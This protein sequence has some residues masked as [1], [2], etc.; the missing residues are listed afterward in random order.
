MRLQSDPTV[1][2]ALT[3]GAAPL[4]R[5]LTRDDLAFDSPFNT[6][7]TGGLPPAPIANPGKA[8]IDA[9]LNPIDTN[10][11]YF[12]AD[13]NGGHVFSRTLREHQRNV[14][15]WRRLKRQRESR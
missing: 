8:A 15:K 4:D 12:V 2:Y 3:R 5:A 1:A 11:L 10:E 6:Y 9:A 7:R 13:G 14:A